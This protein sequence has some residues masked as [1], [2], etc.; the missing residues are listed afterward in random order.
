MPT[1][2]STIQTYSSQSTFTTTTLRT[3][4]QLDTTPSPILDIQTVTPR[5]DNLIMQ[6]QTLQHGQTMYIG[7]LV[8]FGLFFIIAVILIVYKVKHPGNVTHPPHI[9]CLSNTF[10]LLSQWL[11]QNNPTPSYCTQSVINFLTN[12]IAKLLT[13]P[14]NSPTTEEGGEDSSSAVGERG[15]GDESL[16]SLSLTASDGDEALE[17][18]VTDN[19]LNP[20]SFHSP[21]SSH[22]SPSTS[23]AHFPCPLGHY[24]RKC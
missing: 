6:I 20:I 11:S 9:V 16:I 4:G 2:T 19:E 24:S 8:G 3:T 22:S 13:P 21:V 18:V 12:L 14:P 5:T 17:M 7:F 1:T 10:F 23:N 15:G